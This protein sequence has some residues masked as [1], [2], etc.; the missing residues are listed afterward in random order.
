MCLSHMEGRRSGWRALAIRC[1]I[2]TWRALADRRDVRT[3]RLLGG[4][5]A[6]APLHGRAETARRRYAKRSRQGAVVVADVDI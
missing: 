3:H 2:A 1:N 5:A 6:V 4:T